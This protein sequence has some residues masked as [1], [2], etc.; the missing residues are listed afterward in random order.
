[1]TA[2]HISIKRPNYRESLCGRKLLLFSCIQNRH[3]K[4]ELKIK[5]NQI[6]IGENSESE[7][8]T[9]KATI[10]NGNGENLFELN[11]KFVLKQCRISPDVYATQSA[12]QL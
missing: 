9:T 8:V 1:M 6:E 12:E 4:K 11:Q 7:Y 2:T 5:Y 10:E 3:R